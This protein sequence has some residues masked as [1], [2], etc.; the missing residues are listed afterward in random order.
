MIISKKY[1][2]IINYEC[3]ININNDIKYNYYIVFFIN[4]TLSKNYLEYLLQVL[5]ILSNYYN[6]FI[7][8][9]A[10]VNEEIELTL[11]DKLNNIKSKEISKLSY[12]FYYEDNYEYWGILKVWEISQTLN[13][14]T[15]VVLYLHSKGIGKTDILKNPLKEEPY[16]FFIADKER[17]NEI[18]SIFPTINKIG[19][20]CGGYG[21]LWT[22]FWFS[23]SKFIKKL[24]KP[25]RTNIRHYYEDWISRLIVKEEKYYKNT[26]DQCYQ[27]VIK[28][29]SNGK[30]N[31]K[32]GVYPVANIGCYY[33]PEKISYFDIKIKHNVKPCCICS[34]IKPYEHICENLI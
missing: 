1:T 23:R 18:F 26:L 9:I 5:D 15:D 7:Y 11:R 27:I 24:N 3:E 13:S 14:E 34:I 22:N 4:C 16:Y 21:C 29:F 30:I 25:I 10:T 8:I 19:Y 20:Q 28:E 31:E 6:E 2:H 32:L 17:I 12:E 33:N